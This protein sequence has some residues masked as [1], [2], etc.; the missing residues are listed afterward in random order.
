MSATWP[1]N[2]IL[3]DI[4][5][6]GEK[7]KFMKPLIMPRLFATTMLDEAYKSNVFFITH[8]LNNEIYKRYP[9]PTNVNLVFLSF[10]RNIGRS[11]CTNYNISENIYIH[12]SVDVFVFL[13]CSSIL[14]RKRS[15]IWKH[16]LVTVI[17]KCLKNLLLSLSEIA[18]IY[19]TPAS[20]S[21]DL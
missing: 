15:Q 19:S 9:P 12:F 7:Y 2:L 10:M 13:F 6:F 20:Y 3:L 5:I 21:G 1:A 18:S 8:D 14:Q 17:M 4:M 16:L 11:L